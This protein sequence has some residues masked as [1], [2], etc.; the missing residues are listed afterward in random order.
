MANVNVGSLIDHYKILEEI[1]RGGMGVV[2]KALNVNLDK[3]VAVKTIALGLA[4]DEIFLNRFR[5]EARAGQ[6]AKRLDQ[7]R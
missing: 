5:T 3:V 6:T 4:S 2:F 1:G 7:L